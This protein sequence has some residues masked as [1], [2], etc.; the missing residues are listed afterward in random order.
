MNLSKSAENTLLIMA[1]A[2]DYYGKNYHFR[3]LK[4][5]LDVKSKVYMI[6]RSLSTINREVRLFKDENFI[7][8]WARTTTS[9]GKGRQFSSSITHLTWKG[10]RYLVSRKILPYKFIRVWERISKNSRT[11][12]SEYPSIPEV[13]PREG[14]KKNLRDEIDR[15]NK[16]KRK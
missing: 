3:S 8:K 14:K 5:T 9:K 7:M 16:T 2:C 10:V 13:Q 6:L 12:E 1:N 15:D 11:R 4:Q